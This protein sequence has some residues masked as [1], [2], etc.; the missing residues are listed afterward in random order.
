MAE[1]PAG[2][3]TRAVRQPRTRRGATQIIPA[4]CLIGVL[5]VAA[6]AGSAQGVERIGD[7]LAEMRSHKSDAGVQEKGCNALVNLAAGNA[8]NK[9]K[10]SAAGGIADVLAAMR[11]HRS[12]AGVQQHGCHALANLADDIADNQVIA[13]VLAAMRAHKIRV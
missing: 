3:G 10:I 11:A 2:G 1:H 13:D 12:H 8:D 6:Q 5:L 9:V 4:A 7:V